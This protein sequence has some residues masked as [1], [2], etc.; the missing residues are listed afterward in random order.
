MWDDIDDVDFDDTDIEDFDEDED[1]REDEVCGD[2]VLSRD[3]RGR[4][5]PDDDRG[6][7]LT[8]G[9]SWAGVDNPTWED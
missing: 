5:Y 8:G 7:A 3:D 9:L 1:E 6:D 2:R 4:W